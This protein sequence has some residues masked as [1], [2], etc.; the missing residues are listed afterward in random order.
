MSVKVGIE[1]LAFYIPR[2]Y[3]SLKTLAKA[4]GID[5]NKYIQGLGQHFMAVNPPDEGIVT[6]AAN[7]AHQALQ[8]VNKDAITHV[9]F[10]TESGIDQ[11]KSAGVFVHHLLKLNNRCRVTELKQACYSAT[12]GLQMGLALIRQDPKQKVLLIASDIARYGLNTTGESSQGGGAVAMVLS[13]NPKIIAIDQE[14]GYYTTDVMDFFRP[15]YRDEALVD[16]KFSCE[17]YLK[18]LKETWTQYS[19]L[20]GHNYDDHTYFCYH[21]PIPRLAEKA[22]Q[23]LA[24]LNSIPHKDEKFHQQVEITLNYSRRIG[25]C[26]S[27]SLFLCFISLLENCTEDLTNKRV[28]FYSYG[29]GCTGEFFSGTVQVGYQDNMHKAYHQQ[30]LSQREE[31]T[32]EKYEHFYNFKFPTDGSKFILPK[33]N[34]GKYRLNSLNQHK[35]MYEEVKS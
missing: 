19:E 1:S 28:G 10:A 20:S 7:A 5:E 27:A 32:Q 17:M 33:H 3:L 30:Q 31:L 11:S 18:L 8:G 4:R 29:S 22:H 15:N 25:N 24:W 14:S 2:Y 13:A 34:T 9:L 16:G 35:R 26:Y 12:V 21:T 6:M 23:K